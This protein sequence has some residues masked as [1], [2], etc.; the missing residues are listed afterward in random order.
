[1]TWEEAKA[2]A[3]SGKTIM[4]Q[5]WCWAVVKYDPEPKSHGIQFY[6][7]SEL[8]TNNP[9]YEPTKQDL[10]ATDWMVAP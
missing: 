3:V 2:E 1:M 8:S 9:L 4:R 7:E 5:S 10:R 6:I